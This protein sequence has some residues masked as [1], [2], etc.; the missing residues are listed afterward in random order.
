MNAI[1]LLLEFFLRTLPGLVE[2]ITFIL[3]FGKQHL[4]LR[5]FSYMLLFI[6]MRDVFT[7]LNVWELGTE[8]VFWLRMIEDPVFL[9]LGSLLSIFLVVVVNKLDKEASQLYVFIKKSLTH[10]LSTGLIGLL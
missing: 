4:A 5:I 7:P 6:V 3:L 2:G 8:G 1:N 10:A 9:I